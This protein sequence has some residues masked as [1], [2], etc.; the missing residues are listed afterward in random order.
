MSGLQVGIANLGN[1]LA[2]VKKLVFD[3][4][5][6]GQQALGKR[7]PRFRRLLSRSCVSV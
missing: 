4:G 5:M 3:Q 2:A 7:W 1:S 6:I